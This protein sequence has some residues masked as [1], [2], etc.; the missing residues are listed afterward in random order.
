[1]GTF[2]Q[3]FNYYPDKVAFFGCF[4][5]L[6]SRFSL[7]FSIWGCK[8]SNF[9]DLSTSQTSIFHLQLLRLNPFSRNKMTFFLGIAK[10]RRNMDRKDYMRA[11]RRQQ[12]LQKKKCYKC[13]CGAPLI[14][15]DAE[16]HL[17]NNTALE[18]MKAC[19]LNCLVKNQPL[20][21]TDPPKSAP[22]NG[23]R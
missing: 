6:N 16:P 7:C 17:L 15:M 13:G 14:L 23:G 22:S 18:R 19:C 12:I 3:N 1:M 10:M 4:C 8:M 5:P 20:L 21:S 2:F 11:Y 9:L